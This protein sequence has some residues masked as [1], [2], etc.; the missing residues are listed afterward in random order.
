MQW[1]GTIGGSDRRRVSPVM[2]EAMDM[3]LY[4]W[5]GGKDAEGGF[6]C[7]VQRRFDPWNLSVA[8]LRGGQ[9][10]PTNSRTR[11]KSVCRDEEKGVTM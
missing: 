1:E 4:R 6:N 7:F 8:Q 11:L 5:M 9:S 2:Y 3:G 10:S